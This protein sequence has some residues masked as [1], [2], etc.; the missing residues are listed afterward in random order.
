MWRLCLKLRAYQMW[1]SKLIHLH[2]DPSA[3]VRT[4]FFPLV[5]FSLRIHAVTSDPSSL[6]TL[7]LSAP[8]V[9]SC[10]PILSLLDATL[11]T[12]YSGRS[13]RELGILLDP[14]PKSG[15]MHFFHNS[16]WQTSEPRRPPPPVGIQAPF[17]GRA[18]SQFKIPS[19][20]SCC[21]QASHMPLA[22]TWLGPVTQPPPHLKRPVLTWFAR[23]PLLPGKFGHQLANDIM[24][25]GENPSPRVR[26]YDL[27]YSKG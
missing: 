8:S 15:P 26:D 14:P 5:L 19:F 12:A 25:V 10:I 27:T 21:S 11:G 13:S 2:T 23:S 7:A 24:V 17:T 9:D 4:A 6:W 18:M 3:L 20:S 22:M 1:C 16:A